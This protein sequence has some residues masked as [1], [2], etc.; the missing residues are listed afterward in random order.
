MSDT[1]LPAA[2]EME[3]F[4]VI[5][6]LPRGEFGVSA[7]QKVGVTDDELARMERGVIRASPAEDATMVDDPNDPY[8]IIAT[9]NDNRGTALS[10]RWGNSSWGWLK[11]SNKHN[12]TTAAARTTTKYPESRVVE[13]ASAIRYRTPVHR[14]ECRFGVCQV[15]ETK[16]VRVIANPIRLSDGKAKGVITAYCEGV[17]WCPDWVKNAINT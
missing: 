10:M 5:G 6:E 14:V 11:V 16:T 4:S 7:L 9:W 12:L 15:V 8:Q 13:S 3:T 17:V 1:A 2:G